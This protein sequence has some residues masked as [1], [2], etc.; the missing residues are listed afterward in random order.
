MGQ[1]GST[2]LRSENIVRTECTIHD[3]LFIR[4]Q[5]QC[6]RLQLWS[7]IIAGLLESL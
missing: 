6:L 5:I 4:G 3:F 7:M 2:R 1:G